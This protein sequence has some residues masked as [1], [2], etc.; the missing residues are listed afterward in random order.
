ML[1]T[2]VQT[3]SRYGAMTY[4]WIE[5][6]DYYPFSDISQLDVKKKLCLI[7]KKAN[8]YTSVSLFSQLMIVDRQRLS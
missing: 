5:E 7:V 1:P 6:F 4:Q 2:S 8:T 3:G